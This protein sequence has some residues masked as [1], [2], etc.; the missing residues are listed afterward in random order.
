MLQIKSLGE[1]KVRIVNASISDEEGHSD[2]GCELVDVTND[3]ECDGDHCYYH[4][5][6]DRYLV[7][8]SL[9]II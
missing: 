6:V 3:D 7:G 1:S 9:Q 5:R 8:T 4:H 2:N